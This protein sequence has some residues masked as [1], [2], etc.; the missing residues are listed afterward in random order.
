MVNQRAAADELMARVRKIAGEVGEKHADFLKG[1]KA[2]A[3]NSWES[4][5]TIA[6]QYAGE[7]D[8]TVPAMIGMEMIEGGKLGATYS[9]EQAVGMLSEADLIVIGGNNTGELTPLPDVQAFL[10]GKLGQA[11]PAVK[12]GHTIQIPSGGDRSWT[13]AEEVIGVLD[14][15]LTELAGSA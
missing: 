7:W 1:R 10:D 12:A 6:V 8:A 14:E 5:G 11:I 9:A 13:L 4:D 2:L 3:V 15:R